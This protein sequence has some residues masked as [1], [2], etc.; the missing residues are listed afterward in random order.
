MKKNKQDSKIEKELQKSVPAADVI[1]Q[2]S[3]CVI[4][5]LA[6][7]QRLKGDHKT[8]AEVADSLLGLALH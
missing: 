6:L 3:A 1:P 5:A 4:Y 7:V 2:P 8:F